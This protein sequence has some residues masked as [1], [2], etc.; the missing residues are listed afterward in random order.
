MFVLY[1]AIVDKSNGLGSENTKVRRTWTLNSESEC[2][3]C[4]SKA[5]VTYKMFNKTIWFIC[6]FKL[7]YI[8]TSI[9]THI[10]NLINLHCLYIEFEIKVYMSRMFASL[11]FA[12]TPCCCS[13]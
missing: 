9:Y 5:G 12:F 2:R 7:R 10:L 8:R 4:S 3:L 11:S 6:C 13:S 1:A